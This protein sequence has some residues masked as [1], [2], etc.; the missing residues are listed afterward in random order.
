M[1]DSIIRFVTDDELEIQVD[2]ADII[3][4]PDEIINLT[5]NAC[6]LIETLSGSIGVVEE[7]IDNLESQ[8]TQLL[9]NNNKYITFN[10]FD[11]HHHDC[12]YFTRNQL[13]TPALGGE[14]HWDN[15]TSLGN[16]SDAIN[17]I[18]VST[19]LATHIAEALNASTSLVDLL[20]DDQRQTLIDNGVDLDDILPSANNPYVTFE[21]INN[22][23]INTGFSQVGHIHYVFE[24]GETD[25]PNVNRGFG[26]D[27]DVFGQ[28]P[29]GPFDW[30]D[31]IGH[32]NYF[33]HRENPTG[34]PNIDQTEFNWVDES[35]KGK[36]VWL[37]KKHIFTAG[38]DLLVE[39]DTGGSKNITSDNNNVLD[40][41]NESVKFYGGV[42]VG[43]NLNTEGSHVNF[44]G[45][46]YITVGLS[47]NVDVTDQS[48]GFVFQRNN[49]GD[50]DVYVD[51]FGAIAEGNFWIASQEERSIHLGK[52]GQDG[53]NAWRSL[54]VDYDFIGTGPENASAVFAGSVG[55]KKNLYIAGELN[56]ETSINVDLDAEIK[57]DVFLATNNN[58]NIYTGDNE[59][60]NDSGS[61]MVR[62][63]TSNAP[64]TGYLHA[65]VK[66][67]STSSNFL[68]LRS[69]TVQMS[70]DSRFNSIYSDNNIKL[71]GVTF[72]PETPMGNTKL[73]D[74]SIE[75]NGSPYG[76]Y[77][78]DFSYSGLRI[79]TGI[80]QIDSNYHDFQY[81]VYSRADHITGE[82]LSSYSPSGS[83]NFGWVMSDWFRTSSEIISG[84]FQPLHL[85]ASK[86]YVDFCIEEFVPVTLADLGGAPLGELDN[87][88]LSGE[89]ANDILIYNPNLN[90]DPC[91]PCNNSGSSVGGWTNVPFTQ[92]FTDQCIKVDDLC[93]ASVT[94]AQNGDVLVYDNEWV[95]IPFTQFFTD[96]DIK[97]SDLSDTDMTDIEDGDV[98]V[99]NSSTEIWTPKNPYSGSLIEAQLTALINDLFNWDIHKE[100]DNSVSNPPVVSNKKRVYVGCDPRN[101]SVF[102]TLP[103]QPN[104][105]DTWVI[106]DESG[107]CGSSSNYIYVYSGGGFN[108]DGAE[109]Y[110]IDQAYGSIQIVFVGGVD[111]GTGV[112]YRWSIVS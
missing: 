97:V 9:T 102:V 29:L 22:D 83:D 104:E 64:Q 87:V 58:T 76:I 49:L 3:N 59:I 32:V 16:L 78:E 73:D 65:W 28:S 101:N 55:I 111:Y 51:N 77:E 79:N 8:V 54:F 56:L 21:Y 33:V 109:I 43:Q 20:S 13:K 93:D 26:R 74:V 40:L 112:R 90:F 15:L 44:R 4:I 63:W 52:A 47:E 75:V 35:V 92:F 27:S 7:D 89:S 46:E 38:G 5:C 95:N 17:D 88:S 30:S 80:D 81:M 68:T 57:G 86:E 66:D 12:R 36:K 34:V 105:G 108:I 99:Y 62:A 85:V 31:V 94:D 24:I 110:Q 96:Q 37:G 25:N 103:S 48:E 91:D 1:S 50:L 107:V 19:E 69:T 41:V 6:S 61:L 84:D 14:V 11:K 10:I 2:W 60:S 18:E 39:D 45:A 82:K 67:F 98:L 72:G 23:F 100:Y 53:N 42:T 70:A 71:P 106:K